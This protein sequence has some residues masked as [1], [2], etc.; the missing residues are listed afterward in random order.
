MLPDGA[1]GR[2]N[3]FLRTASHVPSLAGD[4]EVRTLHTI[5]SVNSSPEHMLCMHIN[6]IIH[7]SKYI[8]GTYFLFC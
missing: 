1:N 2:N 5:V 6:T 7:T 3:A 8:T 4:V